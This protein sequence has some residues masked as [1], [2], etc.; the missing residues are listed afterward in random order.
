MR[1]RQ[2][3]PAASATR[4]LA[5]IAASHDL[6]VRARPFYVQER[7]VGLTKFRWSAWARRLGFPE[8]ATQHPREGFESL[9]VKP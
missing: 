7:A 9:R 4:R 2:P 5:V 8:G 3:P 1:S 6:S